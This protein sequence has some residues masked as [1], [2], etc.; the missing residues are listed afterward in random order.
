MLV[1]KYESL[2]YYTKKIKNPIPTCDGKAYR[3]G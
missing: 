2:D 1:G 3:L